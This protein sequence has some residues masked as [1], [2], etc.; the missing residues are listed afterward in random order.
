M[1]DNR[2]LELKKIDEETRN[3]DI[4]KVNY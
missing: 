3:K 4:E 1:D 2:Q